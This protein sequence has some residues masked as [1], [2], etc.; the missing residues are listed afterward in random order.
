MFNY[1]LPFKPFPVEDSFTK[2]LSQRITTLVTEQDVLSLRLAEIRIMLVQF[3]LKYKTGKSAELQNA[4]QRLHELLPRCKQSASLLRQGLF[5]H[6]ANEKQPIESLL[7]G[8][9]EDI[10]VI[11]KQ[12]K[13]TVLAC[14]LVNLQQIGQYY[15][16]SFNRWKIAGEHEKASLLIPKPQLSGTN[17]GF[18]YLQ[19]NI[20]RELICRNLYDATRKLNRF[21]NHPVAA[22]AGVHYKPNPI[23]RD[24]I[25]P[26]MEYAVFSF[27]ALLGGEGLAAPTTV[28]KI[29]E[30]PVKIIDEEKL[31][32][33]PASQQYYAQIHQG[34]DSEVIIESLPELKAQIVTK[35]DVKAYVIQ[36]GQTIEGESLQRLL[37][38]VTEFHDLSCRLGKAKLIE[39][40]PTLT[41]G[42]YRNIFKQKYPNCNTAMAQDDL[43]SM[44]LDIIARLDPG[45][46]FKDY[47]SLD[48]GS[49]KLK[50]QFAEHMA[51]YDFDEIIDALAFAEQWPTLV[52]D[53]HL[54]EVVRLSK[55]LRIVP[56]LFGH[57]NGNEICERVAHLLDI[58]DV[59]QFSSLFIGSLLSNPYDGKSDN[60]IASIAKNNQDVLQSWSIVAIDNDK[61]FAYPIVSIEG[62]KTLSRS[63]MGSDN[64]KL[65]TRTTN[66]Q[67][68]QRH[69]PGIKCIIYCL[70]IMRLPIVP[71]VRQAILN[72]APEQLIL[73]WLKILYQQNQR[74]ERLFCL[75]VITHE[76]RFDDVGESSLDMPISLDPKTIPMTYQ[77]LIQLQNYLRSN[78]Q[79]SH[80][81]IFLA[82]EPIVAQYYKR[83]TE[84]SASPHDALYKIYYDPATIEEIL[85]DMLDT[86]SVTTGEGQQQTYREFLSLISITEGKQEELRTQTVEDAVATF[87][88]SIS[89]QISGEKIW[90]YLQFFGKYFPFLTELPF[91]K[92]LLNQWF[93]KAVCEGDADI[94]M[95]LLRCG[96][97]INY[98]DDA[99]RTAL[100]LA[101]NLLQPS[102]AVIEILM[103]TPGI[104][105][106]AY[107]Q[108]GYPPIF[109]A[110]L[111]DEMLVNSLIEFGIDLECQTKD[112]RQ[113]TIMDRAIRQ[114]RPEYFVL[115]VGKNAGRKVNA[116][117][118][119]NYIRELRE[120]NAWRDKS[121][122]MLKKL[123]QQNPKIA[124]IAGLEAVLQSL[125]SNAST[126]HPLIAQIE[127]L[128][129]GKSLLR[130]EVLNKIF[131]PTGEVKRNNNY[132]RH[133]VAFVEYNGQKIHFKFNPEMPLV[134]IA[135]SRLSYL[136][137]NESMT[138]E[139]GL[140]RFNDAKGQAIPVLLSQHVSGDN[141]QEVFR[142]PIKYK[143][144]QENL[145]E[146]SFS[147]LF[148]ITLL[149]NPEDGKPDNYILC[150]YTDAQ[151]IMKYR[152]IGI[153]NDHAL[154]E[155]ITRDKDGHRTMQVKTV[156]Y[157]LDQMLRSLHPDA[158][159]MFLDCDPLKI[160]EKW[161]LALITDQASCDQLFSKDDRKRLFTV[162]ENDKQSA[163]IL[164][165]PFKP[166]A[167]SAIYEKFVNIQTV[168]KQHP[169]I[170]AL[171][172]LRRVM[173]LIGIPHEEA[174]KKLDNP[175][176]RF[177]FLFSQQYS[178]I[179]AD[180]YGTLITGKKILESANIPQD[181]VIASKMDY[182]AE[183]ALAELR[184][185]NL[186]RSRL[187]EVKQGLLNN[188]IKLFKD[189][190]LDSSREAVIKEINLKTIDKTQQ[191]NIF[192][193]LQDVS[194]QSLDF[195]DCN[196]LDDRSLKVI[197][198]NSPN[199]I[200][201]DI[202]GCTQ[203][204][205]KTLNVIAKNCLAIRKLDLSRLLQLRSLLVDSDAFK[206]PQLRRLSANDCPNLESV[207][208]DAP[209]IKSVD[210]NR[211][212]KLV[213]FELE[214][215]SL[216]QLDHFSSIESP[217]P[218]LQ[219]ERILGQ[220]PLL[221]RNL[222][223]KSDNT[224][225]L[226]LIMWFSR[227]YGQNQWTSE[228]LNGIA[229]TG[230][231]LLNGIAITE[232]DL[233]IIL[234]HFSRQHDKILK[235]IDLRGCSALG[236]KATTQLLTKS[237]SL[238]S[239][240]VSDYS[241]TSQV[242][243]QVLPQ[244]GAINTIIVGPHDEI[245]SNSGEKEITQWQL[246][247]QSKQNVFIGHTKPISSQILLPSGDLVSGSYDKSIK[248][249]NRV[250][251]TC[252]RT[253]KG[254]SGAITALIYTQGLLISAAQ[255]KTIKFWNIYFDSCVKSFGTVGESINALEILPEKG[256]ISGA[257][258]GS[259]RFWDMTGTC[260]KTIQ[261]HRSPIHAL[262]WV[263][264]RHLATGASDYT[265][266]IWDV[267]NEKC[268][269]TLKGHSGPVYALE[270]LVS[271]YLLAS[272]SL[273]KT[274]K[275]WDTTTGE[276]IAT[277]TGH[278]QRVTSLRILSDGQLA[279]ASDDGNI[280]IWAFPNKT[281]S[282]Q[283]FTKFQGTFEWYAALGQIAIRISESNQQV[284]DT[285][286]K[287]IER[288]LGK[289]NFEAKAKAETNEWIFT[290]DN[291][292]KLHSLEQV[293]RAIQHRILHFT[294]QASS[295]WHKVKTEGS[296]RI[297]QGNMPTSG[298]FRK[299]SGPEEAQKV[300]QKVLFSHN[301]A[302]KLLASQRNSPQRNAFAEI[303]ATRL[304]ATAHIQD[305]MVSE[306]EKFHVDSSA[307]EVINRPAILTPAAIAKVP[308]KHV[309]LGNRGIAPKPAA[310][311]DTQGEQNRHMT[312]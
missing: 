282:L 66:Q 266:K 296:S 133:P 243:I 225:D 234:Q 156:I 244:Q 211:C 213:K 98:A 135:T 27:F 117:N 174:F 258:D 97:D 170:N 198:E 59:N 300:P 231:L 164:R 290:S 291:P 143:Q 46:R 139:V 168:L 230:K 308:G 185:V 222:H 121:S 187:Q 184:L 204:S 215:H 93:H 138:A 306:Q 277:L 41:T 245:F 299:G 62:D 175:A 53:R 110:S 31:K 45:V 14:V 149:L 205:S 129:A 249:W 285:C 91:E 84:S 10:N 43:S 100:H 26:A 107:N 58:I 16:E 199:L 24:Y 150:P 25:S 23:G 305:A 157:C 12:L 103:T 137:F 73:D 163:V 148:L 19:P 114:Q 279:S 21:G 119:F 280:R 96:A 228:A 94:T 13:D 239:I 40:L 186:E 136:I 115:L 166:R 122:E 55:L 80:H 20:A 102:R 63:S 235:Q 56:K 252:W 28:I 118:A 182:H 116:Q 192:K 312:P 141:L 197:L 9:I 47:Q 38:L 226:R 33:L 111:K 301:P 140:F 200:E 161:L 219:L 214:N 217:L 261:A 105:T 37:E 218:L 283:A 304:A 72:L 134:E 124:W 88:K 34:K 212:M 50:R 257:N 169:T 42:A 269:L 151:N 52:Q 202:S 95:L 233:I 22:K 281:I 142:D 11:E 51:K 288:V 293:L 112:I 101:V 241:V 232:A 120:Q 173:P 49:Q 220:S 238:E 146:R 126:S 236:V 60:Y 64:G 251:R 195:S 171:G 79:A 271:E 104:N 310:S 180:R 90:Q 8:I 6:Q 255:D 276:C 253:L 99:G 106:N 210:V 108:E 191:K 131:T 15:L 286:V 78:P 109:L 176:A 274:I 224:P 246:N 189:L 264:D 57:L 172:L 183:G 44:L 201:L 278:T 54:T 123:C 162:A 67:S 92:K 309:F 303:N 154:V 284:F 263:S 75:N 223:L 227:F 74:Y 216:P 268:L 254:H 297:T 240:M 2:Q 242:A 155:P 295:T 127:G 208:L 165:I 77:K 18:Y 39:C 289:N 29:S 179:V 30:V 181:A 83:I 193:A 167:I 259:L 81:D 35:P 36:A 207:L 275:L 158:V 89:K 206:L 61:S 194:L 160:L 229:K 203:L 196:E 113:E 86:H 248:I 272:G 262:K 145:D 287:L 153:D 48:S 298:F 7:T 177:K 311:P 294:P 256:F 221:L 265:I 270:L 128:H 307:S 132:G 250:T 130:P 125:P 178:T 5:N 65:Q 144:L 190:L 76:D 267:E 147:L 247:T 1:T 87:I 292:S 70:P 302:V 3:E 82:V 68:L 188:N 69:V 4:V 17:L 209:L 159:R 237:F 32:N 71:K 85:G 273:D 260:R 152:I